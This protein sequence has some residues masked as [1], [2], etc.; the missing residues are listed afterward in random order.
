MKIEGGTE[1][2]EL[3]KECSMKE[4]NIVRSEVILPDKIP[5]NPI[6]CPK[7]KGTTYSSEG[8]Y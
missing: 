4:D 7:C 8:Y 2:G 5:T 1:N 3:R 6:R